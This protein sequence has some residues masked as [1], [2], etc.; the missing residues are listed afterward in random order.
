MYANTMYHEVLSISISLNLVIKF[1]IFSWTV[2]NSAKVLQV[3]EGS[4]SQAWSSGKQAATPAW[5]ICT[6]KTRYL[7]RLPATV[8]ELSPDIIVKYIN[9]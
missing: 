1:R 7:T 2:E 3:C 4:P 8:N 6:L 9:P 5:L